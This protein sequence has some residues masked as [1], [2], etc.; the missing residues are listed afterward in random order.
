MRTLIDELNGLPHAAAKT[1]EAAASEA[2]EAATAA[3]CRRIVGT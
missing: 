1:T 2:T 3:P